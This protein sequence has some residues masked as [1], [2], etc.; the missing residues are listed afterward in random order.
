MKCKH[1][2]VDVFR[3]TCPEIIY[4][5]WPFVSHGVKM[6]MNSAHHDF[7]AQM[8]D[9]LFEVDFADQNP[10]SR[11]FFLFSVVSVDVVIVDFVFEWCD[12]HGV[13]LSRSNKKSSCFFVQSY[14]TVCMKLTILQT[15]LLFSIRD[16]VVLRV[17][18]PRFLEHMLNLLRG[19]AQNDDLTRT[20]CDLPIVF[21][22]A[23]V[24]RLAVPHCF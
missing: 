21:L 1:L 20:F 6:S 19:F 11:H 8:T 23:K 18:L 7:G 24:P 22:L 2:C 10:G 9:V 4:H 14:H 3:K 12:V 5:G 16:C 13:V 15:L 17:F